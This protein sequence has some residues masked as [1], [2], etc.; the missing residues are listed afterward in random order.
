MGVMRL[1]RIIVIIYNSQCSVSGGILSDCG[2][3]GGTLGNALKHVI[4]KH[5]ITYKTSLC[6]A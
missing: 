5:N 2:D 4:I 3:G 6:S 1:L